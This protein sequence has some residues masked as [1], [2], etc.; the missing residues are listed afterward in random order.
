VFTGYSN[1]GVTFQDVKYGSNAQQS[2]S[3]QEIGGFV[4]G[5][6]CYTSCREQLETKRFRAVSRESQG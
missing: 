6:F 5:R 1:V 2:L 4:D 3:V